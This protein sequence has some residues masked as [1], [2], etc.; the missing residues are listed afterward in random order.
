MENA[1]R[2]AIV[3]SGP[4]GLSAAAHAAE[5]GVSHVLLEAEEHL[6]STIHKYQ[7][8]KHVMAEPHALPLRSPLSFAAGKR[9]AVLDTWRREA[10]KHG[11]NVRLGCEVASISGEDGR[12]EV[13]TRRGTFH[14]EKVILAIGVQGNLRKLGVPGEGLPNVEYQLDDPGEFAGETIVVVGAGDAAI[15][16]ALALAESNQVILINRNEEFARCKEGNLAL[17]LAAIKDGRIECRY[18][19]SAASV[20]PLAAEREGD[21]TL[22]FHVKTPTGPDSIDCHRIIA[23]LG[24]TPPRKL[25][26]SFGVRFPNDDPACVPQLSETYESNVKGLHIVGALG[27]CPLIKAAMNQGYEVVEFA[28]GRSIEPA[29]EPLLARKLERFSRHMSVS[30]RLDAI[31]E[32]V[33]LLADLNRLQLREFLLESDVRAPREGEILFQRNDYTNSFFMVVGG[34]VRVEAVV[35]GERT[36]FSLGPGE[37]FGELGLISGRRRSGTVAAGADC[38]L[39]EAPRRAMLKLIA[40]VESVRKRVDDAF[41][42]RAVRAYLAPMLP[43]RELADLIAQG[44]EVRRY[45][46]GD[47]LF[48]EGDA[49]DGLYLVRRGSVMVSRTIAGREV[50]LSYLAA[51]NYVGEMALLSSSPRTATVRAAVAAEAIVLTADAFKRVI[52]RNRLWR[53]ELEARFL[54][55]LRM[56]AAM[57]A[58]PDPGNIIAFLMQQGMGE[59]TDVLLIDESLCIRCNNCEKACADVHDGTSRLDRE[60]GPTYAQIHVPTSCRHCEHPRCMKDCPPDAIHRS[61]GG[62]VFIKDTC[63]GCGNCERNCPYGVIQLAAV[64]P[65]RKPASL[66]SWLLF[67]AGPEPGVEP[68]I[69]GKD[70]PKK[71]VK[72]DMCKELPGG[73]A[74]VRACPTGAA[75]RVSPEQFLSFASR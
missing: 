59:A 65:A 32:N 7:K 67:G 74:C 39:I 21:P 15:E 29:D 28:L 12:F 53:E 23:R 75:V 5:L 49:P 72:C 42:K 71:A 44:V 55:R 11:I 27:G 50:V 52:A 1:F 14:A 3:G 34:E 70:V 16:N 22:T 19:T 47:T 68:K 58:Q 33:P 30:Q 66:V 13:K 62:E 46:S 4:A 8:G 51:G 48:R 35:E 24:A 37:F 17:V 10:G 40:S 41:V 69:A 54:D 64:N 6:S 60:A 63:I 25:V 43:E 56:N 9:E 36:W 73:A 31:Q 61:A 38:V 26:E 57:E 18:G 20:A 2:L 45:A